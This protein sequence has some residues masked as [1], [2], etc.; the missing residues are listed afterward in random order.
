[1]GQVFTE[2]L[3]EFAGMGQVFTD[4]RPEFVGIGHVLYRNLSRVCR[5]ATFSFILV[6]YIQFEIGGHGSILYRD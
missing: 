1:M 3:P 4:I 6:L 5:Y 2:S